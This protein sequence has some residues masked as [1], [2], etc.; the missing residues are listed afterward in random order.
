MLSTP[1]LSCPPRVIKDFHLPTFFF[2][3]WASFSDS[4][5]YSWNLQ[6]QIITKPSVVKVTLLSLC[7]SKKHPRIKSH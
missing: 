1:G 4:T 6:A 5:L 3:V 2:K 7:S